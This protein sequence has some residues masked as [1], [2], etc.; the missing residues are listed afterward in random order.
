MNWADICIIGVIAISVLISIFRGFVRE[1]LSLV[2]WV[3]AFWVAAKLALPASDLLEPYLS[4]PTA[5]VV[6]AFIGVLVAALLAG[7]IINHLIGKLIDKTGLS[8]TDRML[9]AVFGLARGAAIIGLVVLAAGLTP[10]TGELWW[11]N[12][13][14][15]VP[16]ERAAL[17]IVQ[18]MPPDLA[19]HFSY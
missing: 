15:I 10:V 11:Q 7:G 5:R 3:A 9:G 1:I 14:T 13:R 6:L 4:V 2:A 12:A 18:W 19:K 8:G 16:F 17:M